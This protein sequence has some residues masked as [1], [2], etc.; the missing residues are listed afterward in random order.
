MTWYSGWIVLLLILR[1]CLYCGSSSDESLILQHPAMGIANP[2][3]LS[4]SELKAALLQT[5][6]RLPT[7]EGTSSPGVILT[8]CDFPCFEALFDHFMSA[9]ANSSRGGFTQHVSM[10]G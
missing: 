8:N 7:H 4:T 9:I 2:N 5:A 3:C 6:M 10:V 1:L